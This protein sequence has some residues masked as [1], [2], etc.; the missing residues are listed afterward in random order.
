RAARLGVQRG[1]TQDARVKRVPRAA[2]RS[3]CGVEMGKPAQ[4]SQ[5]AR[6]WSAIIKRIL[7]RVSILS[8]SF[9]KGVL[10]I[11]PRLQT[12]SYGKNAWTL[13]KPMA[14]PRRHPLF[15][16]A[17]DKPRQRPGV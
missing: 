1:Q 3:I 14:F 5:S 12:G 2:I 8:P 6:N 4:P 10:S 15:F 9:P 7:G 17:P 13:V 11:I 16:P